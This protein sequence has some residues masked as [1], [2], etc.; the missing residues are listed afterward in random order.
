[1]HQPRH[2][3]PSVIHAQVAQADLQKIADSVNQAQDVYKQLK[4]R[5]EELGRAVEALKLM[6]EWQARIFIPLL[7]IW[8]LLSYS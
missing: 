5:R 6:H 3:T 1:M 2:V 7:L 4:A 8:A